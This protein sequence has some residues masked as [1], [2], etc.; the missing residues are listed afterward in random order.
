MSVVS[1][2][3]SSSGLL[4]K[5]NWPNSALEPERRNVGPDDIPSLRAGYTGYTGELYRTGEWC[6]AGCLAGSVHRVPVLALVLALG[7][8]LVL[9][10]GLRG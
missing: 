9:A 3:W 1:S 6:C 4:S 10:A 8:A 5:A 7:L 2:L